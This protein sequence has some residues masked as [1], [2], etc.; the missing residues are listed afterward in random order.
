MSVR[1]RE[2]DKSLFKNYLRKSQECFETA[3]NAWEASLFYGDVRTIGFWK[4]Q[5]N[6]WYL[7]ELA[8]T[9]PKIKGIGTAQVS[10]TDLMNYL[11]FISDNSG[12]AKFQA[13]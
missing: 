3:S 13:I 1:V 4:H 2:I 5:V 11:K 6:V 9:N 8:K 12:Y 10:Q 7:T